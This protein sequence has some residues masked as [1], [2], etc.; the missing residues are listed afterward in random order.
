M[1]PALRWL[2]EAAAQARPVLE[3]PKHRIDW[4]SDN[5]AQSQCR[6]PERLPPAEAPTPNVEIERGERRRRRDGEPDGDRGEENAGLIH[7][8]RSVGY[9][10][11]QSRW[12]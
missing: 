3:V 11:G 10:F 1:T 4:S 2:L 7:T 9:S 6:E 5:D 8:V 12:V